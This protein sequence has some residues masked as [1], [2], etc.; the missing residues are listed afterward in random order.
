MSEMTYAQRVIDSWERR[1][2][3]TDLGSGDNSWGEKAQRKADYVNALIQDRSVHT[4]VDWGCGDGE[5]ASR[6]KAL[7]YIGIEVSPSA[8][9]LCK[10][11][12]TGPEREWRLYDGF[13]KPR[14]PKADLALS[15]D[16]ILHL[17]DDGLYRRYLELLFGSAPLVCVY[18]SCRNEQGARHVLHRTFIDDVPPE[19]HVIERPRYAHEDGMWLFGRQP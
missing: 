5:V 13:T 12:A 18:S 16:I 9:A 6:I 1:Y 7:R 10:A 3:E 17:V 8:L 2:R 15:L 19:F 11:K 4:V 14:L